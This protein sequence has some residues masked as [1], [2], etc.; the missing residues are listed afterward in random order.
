M[1]II[2]QA[3]NYWVFVGDQILVKSTYNLWKLFS[4]LSLI[5]HTLNK[6]LLHIYLLK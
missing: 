5:K 1:I 3:G 6:N 4:I 2:D